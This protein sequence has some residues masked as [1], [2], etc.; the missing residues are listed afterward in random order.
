LRQLA[1]HAIG[2]E[3][4]ENVELFAARR[5]RPVIDQI[6]DLALA[7]SFDRGMRL[8]DEQLGK[9]SEG[10][11][12]PGETVFKLYDTYG[13]PVDLTRVIA[14]ER[15][16][17][18]DEAGFDAEMDKQRGRSAEF[19]SNETG[20]EDV[21][22]ELEG[23]LGATKFL[24]YETTS[25]SC[26]I[27]SSRELPDGRHEIIA[28]E[29]PFYGESGGQIG[30]IGTISSDALEI[31]V[32]DTLKTPGGLILHLGR[33]KRGL[34]HAGATALFTVD[35]ERRDRIRANHSA[36]HLL[37][38]ALKEV[39]GSHVAQKGSLVAPDRLRFG[40]AHFA[41]MSDDEKRKVE[42]LVNDEIRRNADS[43]IT[44]MS[45]DE[46]KKSGAVALFGEKYGDTVRV[47]RIGSRSVELCGGTHVRRAGDI[48]LFK[49]TAEVG[50][51]QGVRRIEAVTGGGALDWVRRIES[52]LAH[53]AGVVRAAPL[54]AAARVEKLQEELKAQRREIDDLKR[55]M[56][57]GGGGRDLL[58]S[59]REVGGI[60]VL[61]TRADV[62]DPKALREVA[63]QLRDKLKSGVIV[64]GGVADGKVALVAAVTA[65][66]VGR[67]H[68]G[69]IIGE[70]AKLVG[71]KGGGRP[72]LA[73]AGGTDAARLDEALES[74]YK[75]IGA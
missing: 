5:F 12:L 13:F 51:A 52:E 58:S 10:A 57:M 45:F 34:P 71:G 29:T 2:P 24:G 32:V 4:G 38:L 74:V 39:L 37:H 7:R 75:L 46:A 31:E 25:A 59:V 40:F 67:V 41:P 68:A 63:D 35:A 64:L 23:K 14:E 55:K 43:V 66:L 36:T 48:G 47:M 1:G 69:K 54:E 73:Q 9:L 8:I 19:V 62:G 18:V 21:H 60:K 72:D 11:T 42:D 3:R 17:G 53:V 65:D 16:F 15:G 22:K 28:A 6:D 44:V 27:V 20:V 30:D 49:I 50:V 26:K 70:V 33:V 61:S 56:A